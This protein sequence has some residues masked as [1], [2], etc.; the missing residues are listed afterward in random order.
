MP[1]VPPC[2]TPAERAGGRRLAPWRPR[3]PA[4]PLGEEVPARPEKIA[5]RPPRPNPIPEIPPT[6]RGRDPESPIPPGHALTGDPGTGM[7]RQPHG[8]A[9]LSPPQRLQ[10]GIVGGRG[11]AP[12]PGT[13][14]WHDHGYEPAL[15]PPPREAL[16]SR[17]APSFALRT[18]HEQG[19][20][21]APPKTDR[22]PHGRPAGP[23]RSW[24]SP[25]APANAWH[26]VEVPSGAAKRGGAGTGSPC[27]PRSGR[28]ESAWQNRLAVTAAPAAMPTTAAPAAAD[29]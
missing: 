1:S 9:F 29:P 3:P 12:P 18:R 19:H 6:P 14:T 27:H 28:K 13:A 23:M 10:A 25:Y 2:G 4:E 17:P 7:Y 5:T 24:T 15:T 20:R 26:A 8:I 16:R 22:H 21:P 11:S